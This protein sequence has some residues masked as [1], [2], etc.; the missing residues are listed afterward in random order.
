MNIAECEEAVVFDCEGDRLV[1]VLSRPSTPATDGVVIVVGGPQYRAGS[2]RQFVSLAR[3]LTAAGFAVLRFDYRG[4][5]DS[6]GLP[7]DFQQVDADIR[8]AIDALS[9]YVPCLQSVTLWGLCDGAS[10]ALMYAYQDERVSF[11]VLAN[12]WARSENT[13]ARAQLKH[14]YLQRLMAPDFWRKVLSGNFRPGRTAAEVSG[15]IARASAQEEA[16]YRTRMVAGWENFNGRLLLL[17]SGADLTAQ[18]FL[19]YM[20][21]DARRRRLLE[22]ERSDR[23]DVPDADHTFSERKWQAAVE[24]ATVDWLRRMKAGELKDRV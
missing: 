6:D 11:L 2:H 16:D 23:T 24:S 21:S 18:E 13:L 19:L 4:M 20:R 7:R 9:H 10:A 14:Y 5:G 1:A 3:R 15:V 22:H 17:I 12:P 8:A